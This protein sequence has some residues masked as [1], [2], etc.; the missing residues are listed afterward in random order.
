[1][2]GKFENY[3]C[4]GHGSLKNLEKS[5][6]SPVDDAD[7]ALNKRK[8]CLKCAFEEFDSYQAYSFDTVSNACGNTFLLKKSLIFFE[9][10]S[11]D[12]G[13]SAS[14][15]FCECDLQFVDTVSGLPC[16]NTNF[17]TTLCEFSKSLARIQVL[18]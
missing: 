12:E 9:I 14:R 15:A 3:G 2:I 6:G 16:Y 5:Y 8:H 10:F 1:M 18:L 11:A 17:N 7:K 4:T 13:E